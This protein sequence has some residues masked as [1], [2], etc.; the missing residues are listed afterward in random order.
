[1][2]HNLNHVIC[3]IIDYLTIWFK[4]LNLGIYKLQTCVPISKNNNN[5]HN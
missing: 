3:F 1:M 2:Y 4:L 5:K